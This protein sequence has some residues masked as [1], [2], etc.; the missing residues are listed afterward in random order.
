MPRFRRTASI[1]DLEYLFRKVK[2]DGQEGQILYG[3]KFRPLLE[4][5]QAA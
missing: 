1:Y 2:E 4:A 3:Y 5:A